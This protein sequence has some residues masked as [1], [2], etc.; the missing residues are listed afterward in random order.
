MYEI[1]QGWLPGIILEERIACAR[2]GGTSTGASEA[3]C[4][5]VWKEQREHRIGR[6]AYAR[7]DIH[8]NRQPVS[9]ARYWT[10]ACQAVWGDQF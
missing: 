3:W 7:H 1:D 5:G 4:R 10:S 2:D 8:N 6:I 9:A